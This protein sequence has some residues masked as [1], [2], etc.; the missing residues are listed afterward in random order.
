MLYAGFDPTSDSF[1]IG[2][3]MILTALFR[4]SLMQCNP[5]ALIGGATAL[6][7]D[8]SGRTTGTKFFM[9]LF[10]DRPELPRETVVNNCE[11]LAKQLRHLYD[12]VLNY[13]G[14]KKSLIICNNIEWYK[15]VRL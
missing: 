10:L 15:D 14:T 11:S 2:N 13:Y 6:V 4:S 7:G 9:C 5:I 12:N 8:P 3:L 1:H